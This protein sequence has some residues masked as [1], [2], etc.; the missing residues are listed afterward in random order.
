MK[1]MKI[2][3][4]HGVD[5]EKGL[6][7]LGDMEMYNSI[8]NDFLSGYQDRMERIEEYKNASDMQNYAIEVHSLKSDSKYLG[9][10]KLAD[11]A[12]QHEMNSK[13][14]D[15]TFVINNYQALIIEANK[16]YNIAKEYMESDGSGSS[17]VINIPN[18]N[19]SDSATQVRMI[20]PEE[21]SLSTKAILV[22]DDSSI[23]RNFI[24]DIFN[25]KYDVLMA[26]N[27]REV[28]NIVSSNKNQIAALLLDLNMPDM[29]GFEVLEYFKENNLFSEIPVSIISG[30][31]DK[32]SIN[33][34]FEYPVVDML[35]KPFTRDNV[36]LVVEKTVS[37]NQQIS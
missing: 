14:G 2:L 30:V 13:A 19:Q 21:V 28:I 27:G 36:K 24:N 22:A 32:D 29:N 8:L 23:I 4:M 26:S 3:T 11:L 25:G 10:M 34:A 35:N 18:N 5:V 20:S 7:L 15:I 12:Y 31:N 37:F 17:S 33:K 6:E 16:T 9:F 1:D